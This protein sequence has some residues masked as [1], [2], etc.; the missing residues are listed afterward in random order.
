MAELSELGLWEL[1]LGDVIHGV[2]GKGS[3]VQVDGKLLILWTF[4]E[5]AMGAWQ[6]AN[7]FLGTAEEENLPFRI[8]RRE[9]DLEPQF[10]ATYYD[11][12]G[13]ELQSFEGADL[14]PAA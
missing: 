4:G 13:K 11:A 12:D 14:P 10:S 7:D 1:E 6:W 5:G 2:S 9:W 3:V 8:E